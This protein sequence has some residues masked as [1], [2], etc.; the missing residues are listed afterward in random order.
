MNNKKLY[1]AAGALLVAA[2]GVGSIALAQTGTPTSSPASNTPSSAT[3]T[4][5]SYP[6]PMVLSVNG[7]GQTLVRGVAQSVTRD[8]IT[9]SGWG[10]TWTIQAGARGRVIPAGPSGA[11]DLSAIKQGDFVGA[12]GIIVPDKPLTVVATFVRDWTT[13]PYQGSA[14]GNSGSS[15][16]S[17]SS[18]ATSSGSSSMPY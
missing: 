16:G 8:S 13:N 11:N 1:G 3:T 15:G 17:G 9:I 6:A 14:L 7:A 4:P 2:L 10:G 12:Q 5:A 18:S